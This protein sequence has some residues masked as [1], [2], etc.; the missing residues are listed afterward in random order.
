MTTMGAT[1]TLVQP[2]TYDTRT[3][4]GGLYFAE[5]NKRKQYGTAV[6]QPGGTVTV[7]SG[8]FT[9]NQ[10]LT[11]INP[12]GNLAS[13]TT[14]LDRTVGQH[15]FEPGGGIAANHIEIGRASC[16]ERV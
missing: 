9:T 3:T 14:N 1:V 5:F 8:L 12:G 15:V 2:G 4:K 16:R 13:L 11:L 7:P 10:G 6:V